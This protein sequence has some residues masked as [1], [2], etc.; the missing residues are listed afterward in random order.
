MRTSGWRRRVQTVQAVNDSSIGSPESAN[1]A[2]CLGCSYDLRG[3]DKHRCPECGRS[4]HPDN[5]WTYRIPGSPFDQIQRHSRSIWAIW[6]ASIIA[7]GLGVY[8]DD[9]AFGANLQVVVC[10][11]TAAGLIVVGYIRVV[12]AALLLGRWPYAIG[13]LFMAAL[14]TPALLLGPLLAIYMIRSDAVSRWR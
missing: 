6:L 9:Y 2:E 13:L 11:G 5:P 14:F 3:L 10:F 4:F 1:A 7:F 8:S 12:R